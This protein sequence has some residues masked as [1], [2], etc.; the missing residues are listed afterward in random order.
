MTNFQEVTKEKPQDR[1]E[2]T[3]PF[4]Y[5]GHCLEPQTGRMWGTPGAARGHGGVTYLHVTIHHLHQYKPT[6]YDQHTVKQIKEHA[7][8]LNLDKPDAVFLGNLSDHWTG[9]SFLDSD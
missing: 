3:L 4:S 2:A 8:Y 5:A 7:R 6:K 9:Y 1:L